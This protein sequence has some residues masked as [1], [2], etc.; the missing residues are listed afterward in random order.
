MSKLKCI[1]HYKHLDTTNEI[2]TAVNEDT[3]KKLQESKGARL[4]V[5]NISTKNKLRICQVHLTL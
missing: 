1:I 2:I 5:V 3:Y 4:R